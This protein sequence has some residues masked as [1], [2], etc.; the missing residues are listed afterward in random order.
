[1]FLNVIQLNEYI[2]IIIQ[3]KKTLIKIHK[4]KDNKMRDYRLGMRN[5]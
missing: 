5:L 1:M 4:M 3:K 2:N